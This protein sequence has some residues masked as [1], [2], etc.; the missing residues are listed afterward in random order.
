M[1]NTIIFHHKQKPIPERW[2]KESWW[3]SNIK[4]RTFWTTYLLY[5]S[6]YI[7][8]YIHFI[9][10]VGVV[11]LLHQ[12]MFLYVVLHVRL[13]LSIKYHKKMNPNEWL[14]VWSPLKSLMIVLPHFSIKLAIGKRG[15]GL[16]MSLKPEMIYTRQTSLPR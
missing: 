16:D 9:C 4:V 13:L 12:R 7:Y 8:I 14:F 15:K 3:I 1:L 10:D 6:I 11:F 5:I 2:E